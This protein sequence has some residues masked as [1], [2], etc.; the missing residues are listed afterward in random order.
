MDISPQPHRQISGTYIVPGR[1]DAEELTRLPI[2]DQ[3]IT[4]GMGGALPEQP[5]SPAFESVLDV[6]CGVGGW[7][8]QTAVTYP[9][10]SRLVGIDSK[11]RMLV[12]ARE[13]ATQQQVSDR[14]EFLAMDA[15]GI[16]DFPARSFDLV[17]I[18]MGATFVRTWEW[19]KILQEFQRVARPNAVIRV[20]DSD[21]IGTCTSAAFDRVRDLLVQ[22]FYQAGYLFAPD[23]NNL[24]QELPHLMKQ[25]GIGNLQTYA[26]TLEIR[27][28]TPE[29]QAFAEDVTRAIPAII[30]FM[31]KWL[32]LPEDFVQLAQQA[33]SDTQQPDF[34]ATWK[35]VTVWGTTP[36]PHL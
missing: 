15:L 17:N 4:T 20:T 19:P 25:Q 10:I 14:V 7:L 8:I 5:A 23:N 27:G 35:L 13:Q 3:F 12:Y 29:G 9:T 6:G 26:H 30:P 11:T 16:L 2:Q 24:L 18:R 33:I 34:L 31:Q 21:M 1:F 22:T 32:R 36:S 28:D